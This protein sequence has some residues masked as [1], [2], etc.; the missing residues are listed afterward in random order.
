MKHPQFFSDFLANEVDLNKTRLGRLNTSVQ[1]VSEFLSKN[2]DSY[3]KV[4]R[5][6]S[7]GLR[8]IIRPVR[9][10]QEYDADVLLYMAYDENKSPREYISEVYNC[11]KD[12][13]TYKEKVHR[14][15]RCVRIDYAGDFHL[16]IVPC[17]EVVDGVQRICNRD[18]NKPEVTD[19]TGYRDW[20]NDK[21]RITHGNLKRVTRLLKF[22]RDHKEN[23]TAK[24]ILMTTLVGETVYG[25]SD[26]DAFRST[27][28]AL[29]TVSNRINEFLQKN[30]TMP[31]I[32]NPVLPE[33][34]FT[35][36][37]DQRK[38]RNFRKLFNVYNDKINIAF[39]AKEHDDSVDKW[40]D[41]FGEKFGKKRGASSDRN[42]SRK[43][44]TSMVVNPGRPWAK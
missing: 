21:T 35:R 29:K 11:L 36:H 12:N 34:S 18:T 17:I 33:E 26:G 3:R 30:S 32:D 1:A 5:Q 24:S 4:E 6:G 40:R 23:F 10:N 27:P 9:E 42:L 19:G 43:I 25:E 28:D 39:D 2:L 8:T 20:F 38:Y 14:K 7:Y 37:W 31:E 15:T 13:N 16:D 44:A 41:I 22:L